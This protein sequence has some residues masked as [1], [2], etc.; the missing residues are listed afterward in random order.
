MDGSRDIAL[1]YSAAGK[2]LKPG[3]RYTTRQA[4][5][6]PGTLRNEAVLFPGKGVQTG[7]RAQNR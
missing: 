5:D 4:D 2:A 3:L 6:P 1:G 7:V